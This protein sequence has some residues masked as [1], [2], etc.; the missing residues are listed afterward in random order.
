MRF[1]SASSDVDSLLSEHDISCIDRMNLM[2]TMEPGVS[3]PSKSLIMFSEVAFSPSICLRAQPSE[4]SSF[5]SQHK[6]RSRVLISPSLKS[7]RS[8]KALID[9]SYPAKRLKAASIDADGRTDSAG[10]GMKSPSAIAPNCTPSN[11]SQT[12]KMTSPLLNLL[13][14]GDPE[15]MFS[16]VSPV[17]MS[18]I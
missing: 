18:P 9:D 3:G 14:A 4:E 2:V 13:Y 1:L 16:T 10:E 12:S 15:S 6:A 17:T 11:N 5:S 7:F 8:L